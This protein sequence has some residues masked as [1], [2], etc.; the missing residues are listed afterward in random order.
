MPPPM[1]PA[2]RTAARCTG[3]APAEAFFASFFTS[4]SPRK[5]ETR[6]CAV[7]VFA[8][9]AKAAAS[10]FSASSRPRPAPFCIASIAATGDG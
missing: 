8:I 9:F 2:P 1:I 5:T 10:I 6:P 3:F 4:W 7:G